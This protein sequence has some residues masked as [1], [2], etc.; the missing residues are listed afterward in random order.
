VLTSFGGRD[1]VDWPGKLMIGRLLLQLKHFQ[2]FGCAGRGRPLP[3]WA[4]EFG[5]ESWAQLFLKY[6]LAEPAVACV[7]PAT[8]NPDH[9]KDN[10]AA[11]F[12]RLPDSRQRQQIR[13][14]W[15]AG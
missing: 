5:C 2:E 1:D 4:G 11:G 14:M 8:G 6:V 3:E 15:D 10:L 12:G 9:M 13:E 7:I